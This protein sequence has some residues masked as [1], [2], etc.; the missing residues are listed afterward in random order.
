M[1]VGLAA[2]LQAA[3]VAAIIAAAYRP[4]GAYL[5]RTFTTDRDLRIERAIYRL[6]GIDPRADQRWSAYLTAVLAFSL[7]SILAVFG[8]IQLQRH[9]PLSNGMGAMP[10][11]QALNTAI[12]F[13]TNTNWQS[14]SGEQAVGHLAQMAALA[15]QNFV[16][17]AVGIAVAVALIR[18]FTRQHTDRLG[19]FWVDLVRGVLRVLLPGA[20]IAAVLLVLGGV[21]QNLAAPHEITTLSG[22]KQ[23][24][25]GGPVASQEAIKELGT[26]GGGFFN[27]NS[28]HPLENPNPFTNLLEIV[29]ILVI[30]FSLVSAFGIL[31]GDR[32]QGRTIAVVM[33]TILGLMVL[34]TTL[35]E[36]ATPVRPG[37]P[38][39]P[40]WR[41]RR[42]ASAS[43]RARCSPP[44]PPAPPRARS[45]PRTIRS[46]P[47]RAA[48]CCSTW[49]SARWRPAAPA[50]AST[51][52]SSSRWSRVHRGL[53]VGRTPEYLGKRLGPR[54]L[55][56]IAAYILVTPTL[57]LIGTAVALS[58]DGPRSSILN[59]GAHGLTEVLYAFTSAAN[60]NGSAFGGLTSATTFY[61]LALG[62]AM[63]IGRFAPIALILALA[64]SLAASRPCPSRPAPCRRTRASSPGSSSASW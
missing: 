62:A 47:S 52:C 48:R 32:R 50:P 23:S 56:L 25:L 4:L 14:Y 29:L 18:G 20:A 64:A 21:L 46:P 6:G 44:P 27:A 49:P 7:A 11:H 13:T 30:P 31:V 12:S 8:L 19:N 9:L 61:D 41:A 45:T 57:V 17:A 24:L 35:A 63:L 53:M 33:A 60:N 55:K 59:P 51:G 5:A 10:F 58:F 28:A 1:S 22:A 43:R 37:T 16:S 26:N 3:L 34:G 36:L 39:A 15:V 40:R 54:E 38:P 42:C 2:V